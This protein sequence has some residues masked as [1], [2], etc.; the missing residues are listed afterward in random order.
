MLSEFEEIVYS[1]LTSLDRMV[2]LSRGTA[3]TFRCKNLARTVVPKP[4]VLTVIKHILEEFRKKG[5]IDVW[6]VRR[7]GETGR[8]VSRYIL[9]K[10]SPLWKF[11]KNAT[12]EDLQSYM[13]N[14]LKN[15]DYTIP[16]LAEARM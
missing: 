13:E 1:V 5:Y 15:N 3:V 12:I 14:I 16:T 4:V 11:L 10:D 2:K 6:S 8:G 9:T 7:I